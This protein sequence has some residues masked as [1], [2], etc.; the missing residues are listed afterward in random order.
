VRLEEFDG[1]VNVAKA[2][3]VACRTLTHDAD[4]YCVSIGETIDGVCE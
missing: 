4:R 2:A 1:S 3:S